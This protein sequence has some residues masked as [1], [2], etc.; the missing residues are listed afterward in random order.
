ML[1]S[2]TPTHSLPVQGPASRLPPFIPSSPTNKQAYSYCAHTFFSPSLPLSHPR[3]R[4]CVH[5]CS[6]VFP[7][8]PPSPRLLRLSRLHA[9]SLLLPSAPP[10]S[11]PPPS[12]HF[13][14]ERAPPLRPFP[15]A[16]RSSSAPLRPGR[17]AAPGSRAPQRSR[18]GPAGRTGPGRSRSAQ[19]G[20]ARRVLP[21][22]ARSPVSLAARA[23]RPVDAACRANL[24]VSASDG[25]ICGPM[26]VS[27]SGGLMY[28]SW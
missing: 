5:R 1:Y 27:W 20:A 15:A 26:Y 17:T 9:P 25:Q 16:V 11:R 24:S 23:G 18:K 3:A 4:L 19:G 8:A 28:G 10:F 7:S 14:R 12:A 13:R 22:P 6:L 21:G 2:W